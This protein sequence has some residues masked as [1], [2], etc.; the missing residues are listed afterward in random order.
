MI[1][2]QLRQIILDVEDAK[3]KELADHHSQ[4]S[5]SELTFK[6]KQAADKYTELSSKT[7]KSSKNGV[8]SME[9]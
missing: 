8:A 4:P 7:T 3:N 2:D 9:V 6:L 5:N 1:T